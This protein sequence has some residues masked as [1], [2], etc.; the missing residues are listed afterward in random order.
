MKRICWLRGKQ[1]S[2]GPS[3]SRSCIF[4]PLRFGRS[5]SGPAYFDA[6][7]SVSPEQRSHKLQI[8]W[9]YTSRLQCRFGAEKSKIKNTSRL[10]FRIGGALCYLSLHHVR[11]YVVKVSNS[12]AS[13]ACVHACYAQRV[14]SWCSLCASSSLS[15]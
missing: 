4:R 7:G 6:P 8:L 13:I 10:N 15:V 11:H 1:C 14:C 3:Y 2:P 9:K 5:F 12:H